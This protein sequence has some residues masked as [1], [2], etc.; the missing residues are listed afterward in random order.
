MYSFSYIPC[1]LEEPYKLIGHVFFL[2]GLVLYGMDL[3]RRERSSLGRRALVRIE[4][5]RTKLNNILHECDSKIHSWI[6]NVVPPLFQ[7]V[8][9]VGSINSGSSS[10]PLCTI[11]KTINYNF[12][13][14]NH[15]I[16]NWILWREIENV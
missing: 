8:K 6:S 12:S 13:N 1:A 4:A 3:R 10:C 11:Q 14:S 9:T 15:I 16:L 5:R 7:A 2:L